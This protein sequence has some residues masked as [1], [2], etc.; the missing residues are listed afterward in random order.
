[1]SDY[2]PRPRLVLRVGITGHQWDK[3][4][5]ADRDRLIACIGSVLAELERIADRMHQDPVSGYRPDAQEPGMSEVQEPE[6][7]IISALAEGADRLLPAAASSRWRLQ[8][9]LPLPRDQYVATFPN[10]G[11]PADDF[12]ALLRRARSQAGALILDRI[13][14]AGSRFEALATAM[15]VNSDVLLAVWNEEPPKSRGGTGAVVELAVAHGIPVVRIPITGTGAPFLQGPGGPKD[16]DGDGLANL[17]ERVRRLFYPPEPEH[18]GHGKWPDLREKYFREH[19][20]RARLGQ[21]YDTAIGLLAWDVFPSKERRR[22]G[23]RPVPF[24]FRKKEWRDPGQATRDRWRAAWQ[25]RL[26]LP[27]GFVD[28]L[29]E[30]PLPT[31]YGWASYLANYYAGRYRTTFLWAFGLAGVA[32]VFAG[33]GFAVAPSGEGHVSWRL[34][35]GSLEFLLLAWV[36]GVVLWARYRDFHE[37]WLEYR[38]LTESLRSLIVTLPFGVPSALAAGRGTGAETWV[39]WMH[40]AVVREIGVLPVEMEPGHLRAARTLLVEGMLREQIRHH[41]RNES[42]YRFITHRLETIGTVAFA[43]ALVLALLHVIEIGWGPQALHVLKTPFLVVLATAVPAFASAAHGF[44]SH[45]GLPESAIRSRNVRR[46]LEQLAKLGGSER[47]PLNSHALGSVAR[48]SV[49]T[50]NAEL[51]AWFASYQGRPPT[52]P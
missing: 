1:M 18:H 19:W 10:L 48:E 20:R 26:K 4:A 11:D 7:R 5:L 22:L 9:I 40:R 41:E 2:P 37:R 32:V 46:Q 51:G 24:P 30:T 17:E 52:L 45:M 16:R 6:L 47:L 3:L 31:H 27:A 8:A 23:R 12:D 25:D 33:L 21:L 35:F 34:V 38:G 28:T 42:D 15:A 29:V 49:A 39:D 14:G 44:L 50:M 43:L 13:E 36:L